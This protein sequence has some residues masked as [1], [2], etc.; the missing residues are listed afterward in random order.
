[1]TQYLMDASALLNTIKRDLRGLVDAST[2]TLARY[3]CLNALWKERYLLKIIDDETLKVLLKALKMIFMVLPVYDVEG[4]EDEILQIAL[5][6]NITV[7]DASYI[8]VA[9]KRGLK[10]ITDDEELRAKAAKHVKTLDSKKLSRL[11]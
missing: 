9:K 11:S 4:L 2:I 6:S 7:Y 10:L 1:M 3:E 8:A 5:K